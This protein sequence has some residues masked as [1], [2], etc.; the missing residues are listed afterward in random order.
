SP[1]HCAFPFPSNRYAAKDP[2]TPTGLRV[3][4]PK[5]M[6]PERYD[7]PSPFDPRPW[8]SLDGFGPG[9]QPMWIVD[10]PL[11]LTGAAGFEDWERSLE[12]DSPTVLLNLDTGER[13]AHF[14]EMDAWAEPGVGDAET[15]KV[16]FL[17][18]ARRLD[19]ATHYAVA[20]RG[21]RYTDGSDFAP[22]RAFLALRDGIPTDSAVV[23]GRR[24]AFET[25]FAALE[26]A[27]IERSSL[28]LAWDFTTASG[29]AL[30]GDLLAMRDDAFDRLAKGAPGGCTITQVD[31]D[32]K[33]EIGRRILGTVELPSYLEDPGPLGRLARD[34]EGRPTFVGWR[35]IEF[36]A[37]VPKVL[38]EPGAPPGPLVLYGHGQLG[39]H[40]EVE[41]SGARTIAQSL[42]YVLVAT[43]WA[44]MSE[45]DIPAVAAA[46]A[47]ATEFEAIADH[48]HQGLVNMMLLPD[49]LTAQCGEA[50]AFHFEGHRVFG[51][52]RYYLG[53][54]QGA[55]FGA[56]LM[57]LHPSIERGV[58]NVG[59]A[60]Y[61]VMIQ[62]SRNFREFES[63]HALWY[64][65]RSDRLLIF[66]MMQQLW[67]RTDPIGYLHLLRSGRLA[68]DHPKKVLYT[69]AKNDVQVP[70]LAS[71]M[72]ARSMDL[73]L[74][75]PPLHPVW[76]LAEVE[77]PFDGSA[78]VYF[79]TGA[80]EVPHTNTAPAEDP[81]AH[82]R[83]RTLPAHLEMMDAF[84]KPDGR[85]VPTCDGPCD[86]D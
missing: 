9:S 82:G 40:H 34:A 16:V 64:P 79:D 30:R 48:L 68:G 42:G 54:S 56:T 63:G 18:P 71:D 27:G 75:A 32:Y 85:V 1:A 12:P 44:G 21:L 52:A 28:Q 13:V 15:R 3:D 8:A 51:E 47:D 65:L 20:V 19:D 11:D 5:A 61:Q 45:D 49:A 58:L 67:D 60:N 26:A 84:L 17:R 72:A 39:S 83:V 4:Y 25:I 23:E 76:G 36:A 62:R 46:L 69:V 38:L 66:A 35:P 73:P 86:P 81:G 74:L 6:F 78:Y 31:E 22:S 80:P 24:E 41:Y 10:R 14:V 50:P 37:V 7:G 2:S 55:I 43:K 59:A 33:P 57:A 77:G 70:N 53:I 29:T